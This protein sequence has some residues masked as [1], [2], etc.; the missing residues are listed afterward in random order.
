MS[1]TALGTQNAQDGLK[2]A[3]TAGRH[4]DGQRV[5]FPR[6]VHMEWIK[7]RSL[8]ST[9]YTLAIIVALVIGFGLLFS[10]VVGS[11]EGPGE[12]DFGDPTSISLG[13]GDARRAGRRRAR[14]ADERQ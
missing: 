14:G 2:T 6:V 9:L 5:T 3:G 11:G 1:T 12:D 8:R 13:R 10:S 4:T 7:L